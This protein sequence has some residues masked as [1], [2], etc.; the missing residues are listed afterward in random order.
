MR[1][2]GPAFPGKCYWWVSDDAPPEHKTEEAK[3]I[4]AKV[5]DFGCKKW[6]EK[7]PW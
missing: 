2:G 4:P 7:Q 3:E 6:K 1:N 5:M